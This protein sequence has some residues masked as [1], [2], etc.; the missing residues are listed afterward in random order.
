MISSQRTESRP[1]RKLSRQR[2]IT[3]LSTVLIASA[4]ATAVVLSP[5]P[6]SAAVTYGDPVL[7]EAI[8]VEN[9]V[10]VVVDSVTG[11][12][13][14]AS[15]PTPKTGL[16]SVIDGNTHE[17]IATTAL[18]R[19]PEA[20]SLTGRNLS[21]ILERGTIVTVNTTTTMI[22]NEFNPRGSY[23]LYAAV[24]DPT[25]GATYYTVGDEIG[26]FSVA[27]F[28]Y[29][30][31]TRTLTRGG[32]RG[33]RGIALDAD[34]RLLAT[35][36]TDRTAFVLQL[37]PDGTFQNSS[38]VTL[39]VPGRFT[40]QI[41]VDP[42]T[43]AFF[44][45]VDQGGGAGAVVSWQSGDTTA[46][47]VRGTT[48][49]A[50]DVAATGGDLVV[51]AGPDVHSRDGDWTTT[52]LDAGARAVAVDV[53][54]RTRAI[55]VADAGTNT[56]AVLQRSVEFQVTSAGAPAE[57]ASLAQEYTA[58][59]TTNL[60]ADHPVTWAVSDGE[61]PAG[62][63]LDPA[64]G[65]ITGTPAQVGEFTFTVEAA[66]AGA[67]PSSDLPTATYTIAVADTTTIVATPEGIL[68]D[69]IDTATI[70]I[71]GG[72]SA[73]GQHVTLATTAGT[74]S[75]VTDH[76]DGSYTAILTA[77]NT[78]EPA[79]VTYT[80]EG[81]TMPQ[82]VSVPFTTGPASADTSTITAGVLD[83]T[84]PDATASITVTLTDAA[85]HVL[86]DSS[87]TIAL[88]TSYGTIGEVVN[89]HDGTYTA[90]LAGT[91]TSGEAT[92]SFSINGVTAT[93]TTTVTFAAGRLDPSRST[94][95]AAATT[96]PADSASSTLITVATLDG[97]GDSI[98]AGGATVTL[99]TTAGTLSAVTD[100]TDGSYTA[101][102]TS[103]ASAAAATITATTDGIASMNTAT[104]VFTAVADP[105]TSTISAPVTELVAD[106]TST[107][108]FTL[109]VN[110]ANGL[111][112]PGAVV[113]ATTTA[114][115]LSEVTDHGDGTYTVILTSPVNAGP[116]EVTFTVNG[117][118]S[119]NQ[120]SLEFIAGAPD[121]DRSTITASP[122]VITANG[123]ASTVLVVTVRDAHDNIVTGVDVSITATGGSV[124]ATHG[125]SADPRHHGNTTY[126]STL[127]A[128]TIAGDAVASFTVN[129]VLSATNTT[130]TFSADPASGIP[131][132]AA[133]SITVTEPTLTAD[134]AA[135]T[136]VFVIVRD[137]FGNP[138]TDATVTITSSIGTL[139]EVTNAGDGNYTTTLTSGTAVAAGEVLYTAN[140]LPGSSAPVQF[141]AGPATAA[142]SSVTATPVTIVADATS[143]SQLLIRIADAFGN[144]VTGA[145]V[146]LT[147]TAGTL[148]TVT[149]TGDGRYLSTLTSSRIAETATVTLRVG[150]VVRAV[151]AT[152]EF[153]A[154]AAPTPITP[155]DQTANGTGS[156]GTAP[157]SDGSGVKALPATGVS[158]IGWIAAIATTLLAIGA[159][160]LLL[161]R[162]KRAST[163]EQPS[164]DEGSPRLDL[165]ELFATD[166]TPTSPLRIQP[167]RTEN[168]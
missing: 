16:L 20:L 136:P 154:P 157:G 103:P 139:G 83:S 50:T 118:Q 147:T 24:V 101:L 17:V 125:G 71:T 45:T 47:L 8:P 131:D 70:R 26:M 81:V 57:N 115:T 164:I 121:L 10:D 92:V 21:I 150:N 42:K 116:G 78:P 149:E 88:T 145:A 31:D 141:V 112:A 69:G 49:A 30:G 166:T 9:P 65:T 167:P 94:V 100:N 126:I 32:L 156:G 67:A 133:S 160:T 129:G 55:Y 18:A 35:P 119:D 134:G 28:T 106:G 76:E 19:K 130:V 74:L 163:A 13:Y 97:L 64:T 93:N 91:P 143:A 36:A 120:A 90:Q 151:A 41:A 66:A 27:P 43:G 107:T 40:G 102:L 59:L 72:S 77:S 38:A 140:T 3:A 75:G 152:V 114:G 63:S 135:S 108:T 39:D 148:T 15:A 11:T 51:V 137:L 1:P 62:I 99:T 34:R 124:S 58:Q 117:V 23:S 155:A 86:S 12:V 52:T 113:V 84:Q 68:A 22:S 110:D 89:N 123:V 4:A 87:A 7:V 146:G 144:P 105:A 5:N 85:G 98:V 168:N 79:T 132:L 60:P 37:K 162:R 159:L 56:V 95:F 61:L 46:T 122:N 158:N 153:T 96:L 128:P 111:P 109:L 14:V 127:T 44:A 138:V 25:N 73:G 82:H 165:D 53:N 2:L 48:G 54:A 104:V 6:A 161:R 33:P 142:D 29:R 80:I